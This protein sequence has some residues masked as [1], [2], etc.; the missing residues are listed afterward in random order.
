MIKAV[1][2]DVDGTLLNFERSEGASLFASLDEIGY[3]EYDE[4]MRKRY[5]FINRLHWEALERGEL[6]KQEVLLGR[7]KQFFEQE[8]ISCGDLQAFNDAYQRRLGEIFFENDRALELCT[9]LKP[10]IRQYVVTNGTITVQQR[11]LDASGLGA[12]MDE[13]FISDAIGVEKPGKGFFDR[14]FQVIASQTGEE[15]KPEELLIV[16]DSL[17]SDIRG[18]NNAGIL[19]CWYNPRRL[20]NT[21]GVRVDYE[22]RHLWD[23]LKIL[24]CRKATAN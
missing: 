24:E 21:M 3:H 17:T 19:C 15:P 18:G 13:V 16:G 20:P 4:E 14:V 12:C 10:R 2:W 23:V 1:L 22:I 9:L 6:T 5:S 7:F 8:S 11:K